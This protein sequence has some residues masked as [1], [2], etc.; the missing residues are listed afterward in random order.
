MK[1]RVVGVR[2]LKHAHLDRLGK[3]CQIDYFETVDETN[4]AQFMKKLARAHGLIGAKLDLTSEMIEAA[5]E[6]EAISTISAGYDNLPLASIHARG[7]ALCNT[8]AAL[9]E[10]TA[11]LGFALILGC[12]RRMVELHSYVRRGDWQQ[13]IGDDLLGCNVH[14]KTLGVLGLGRI[15][16]ALARRAALGF[17]MN[18]RYA[19]SSP[20][21][22]IEA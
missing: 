17:G 4:R 21:P 19:L 13:H 5:P 11:D 20:K 9:T 3:A 1:K 12:A 14:G 6:L 18:V 15:G 22:A 7:I 2:R 10:T 8:P 16:A